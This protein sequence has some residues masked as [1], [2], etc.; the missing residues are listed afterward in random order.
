MFIQEKNLNIRETIITWTATNPWYK[1]EI[2]NKLSFIPKLPGVNLIIFANPEIQTK[3]IIWRLF[4]W[5]FNKL[6]KYMWLTIFTEI[7]RIV[8]QN[9]LI[10]FGLERFNEFNEKEFKT[11]KYLNL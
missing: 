5:M 10:I 2:I 7:K 11:L 6:N 1:F 8:R 9:N 4:I 3:E